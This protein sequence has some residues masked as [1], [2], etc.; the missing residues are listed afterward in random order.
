MFCNHMQETTKKNRFSLREG[1]III[2]MRRRITIYVVVLALTLFSNIYFAERTSTVDVDG[3]DTIILSQYNVNNNS[4]LSSDGNSHIDVLL[5]HLKE[6][7]D[8]S[9]IEKVVDLHNPNLPVRQIRPEALNVLH[10]WTY[11]AQE[12]TTSGHSWCSIA[13]DNWSCVGERYKEMLKATPI[14]NQSVSLLG[15]PPN[16][17]IYVEGN[18]FIG[19][20]VYGF[21]CATPNV[22][23]WILDGVG[24]D[25][26]VAHVP[27]TN[28]TLFLL[29]NP[30]NLM[31]QI[32]PER[33]LGLLKKIGYTPDYIVR[34]AVNGVK[35][36]MFLEITKTHRML[37][38]NEF[39]KAYYLEYFDPHIP[40]G[41]KGC[42]A[43]FKNCR[44]NEGLGHTCFPGPINT[45]SEN[46]VRDILTADPLKALCNPPE[47]LCRMDH[48]AGLILSCHRQGNVSRL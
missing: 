45:V 48:E 20:L 40:L 46:M 42:P 3:D 38:M 44:A 13:R 1:S 14:F 7:N 33:S 8:L 37:Y 36:P 17:N 43:D 12:V 23:V 5:N 9:K 34:G 4:N 28:V 18:S 19:E 35:V 41:D 25:S 21:V 26:I 32:K 15:F 11:V 22:D 29:C 24:G 47:C 27:K 31:T 10:N 16:S 2:F 30:S 39:P 6:S